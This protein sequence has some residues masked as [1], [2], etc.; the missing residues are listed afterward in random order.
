METFTLSDRFT[1]TCY[2]AA[3]WTHVGKTTGRGKLD[4]YGKY[5]VPVKDIFLYPLYKKFRTIL[6]QQKGSP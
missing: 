1:G 2:R 6:C 3:N 5:P 4:R